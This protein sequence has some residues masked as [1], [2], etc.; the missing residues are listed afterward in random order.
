MKPSLNAVNDRGEEAIGIMIVLFVALA[1]CII[2][3]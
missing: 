1:W 3:A 2:F